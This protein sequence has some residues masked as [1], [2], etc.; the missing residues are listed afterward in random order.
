MQTNRTALFDIFSQDT[1]RRA[2]SPFNRDSCMEGPVGHPTI[3]G[4]GCTRRAAAPASVRRFASR[5]DALGIIQAAKSNST[6][7]QSRSPQDHLKGAGWGCVSSRES[8]AE[9]L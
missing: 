8:C 9:V 3:A 7:R 2:A 5:H 4:Q 1:Q 6:I